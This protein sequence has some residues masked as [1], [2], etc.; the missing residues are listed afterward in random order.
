MTACLRVKTMPGK[1]WT[2]DE[3]RVLRAMWP[4]Y[5]CHVDK[6][7]VK[8]N[9]SSAAVMQQAHR[10]G[11]RSKGHVSHSHMSLEQRKKLSEAWRLICGNLHISTQ[12]GIQELIRLNQ[13]GRL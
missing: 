5:G 11:I 3:I 8:V 6:W 9:R 1:M 2:T 13:R 12:D 4:K 7:P 10:L